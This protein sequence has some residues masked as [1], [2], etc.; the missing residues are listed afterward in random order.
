MNVYA[1]MSLVALCANLLVGF[2]VLTRGPRNT[3]NRLYFAVM[4]SLAVWSVGE[5]MMRI[6]QT[7]TSALWG[8]C[9]AAVGW[10]FVGGFFVLFALAFSDNIKA[11]RDRRVQLA[12]LL[13]GLAVLA[14]TWSTHTI[15]KD[16]TKSY[17]G[18]EEV[19][20]SLRL[21][22]KLFVVAMFIIGGVILLRFFLSSP[23]RYKKVGAG[24]VLIALLIPLSLIHIS[25]PTRR[26]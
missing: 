17:W 6:S 2:Y 1:I 3:L 22:S 21:P 18:F 23:T 16:F 26:T 5:F 19:A 11:V 13:P 7:G 15:F 14:L 25:E 10:C 24:Y 8:S 4:M 9:I 12:C 20:G